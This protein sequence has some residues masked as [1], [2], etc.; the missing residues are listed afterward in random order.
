MSKTPR[1][2]PTKRVHTMQTDSLHNLLSGMGGAGDKTMFTQFGHITMQRD[3]IEAAY[4]ND[5][6]S[7]KVIDIP[8]N[9]ATR[10]W[11]TWPEVLPAVPDRP[12]S[13]RTPL[14]SIL[15]S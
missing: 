1:V 7:R 15:A 6:I 9:D 12:S 3:Q 2:M 14:R 4:R 5:W 8:A 13:R 10:E 11:R